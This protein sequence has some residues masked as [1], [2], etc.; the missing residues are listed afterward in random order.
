MEA[1]EVAG[2]MGR[3]FIAQFDGRLLD[4][5]ASGDER[6]GLHLAQVVQ[7]A[8]GALSRLEEKEPF[9]LARGY[10]AHPGEVIGAVVRCP[11]QLGPV[12]DLCETIVHARSRR[13]RPAGHPA[14]WSRGRIGVEVGHL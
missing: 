7:P 4:A 13:R 6:N 9:Q 14:R 5:F 8:V 11:G 1:F 10:T 12:R 3:V 2:E